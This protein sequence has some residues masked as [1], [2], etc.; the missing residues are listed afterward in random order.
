VH[1]AAP[2]PSCTGRRVWSHWTHGDAGA[3]P[4]GGPSAL[5]MWR[6]QSLPMQGTGLELQDTWQLRSPPPPGVGFSA[7]GYVVTTEPSIPGGEFGAVGHVATPDP[8]PG[9]WCAR[10]HRACCEARALWHREW[11][12]RRHWSPPLPGEESGA[13]GLD[14]SL[15]HKGTR[16]MGYR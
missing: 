6:C 3:L 1:V 15:M 2:E 8:S 16:S 7:M 5:D 4:S 11:D 13:M 9:G 12:T 14:L 10:C